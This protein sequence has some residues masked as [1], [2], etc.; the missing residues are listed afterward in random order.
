MDGAG[1]RVF[2]CYVHHKTTTCRCIA[3]CIPVECILSQSKFQNCS[4]ACPYLIK[5]A[6][7]QAVLPLERGF[8]QSA[9][10]INI[11]SLSSPLLNFTPCLNSNERKIV[12]ACCSCS[13]RGT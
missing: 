10:D 6:S 3:A 4:K 5:A 11:Y 13:S 12:A 1:T 8:A 9:F 2:Y 7:R